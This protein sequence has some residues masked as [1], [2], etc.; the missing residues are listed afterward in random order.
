MLTMSTEPETA[1]LPGV[2][3]DTYLELRDQLYVG[4]SRSKR[5]FYGE[6]G[7]F[8]LTPSHRHEVLARL[9]SALVQEI[10]MSR[11]LR[12]GSALS[13]TLK[14]VDLHRAAEADDCIWIDNERYDQRAFDLDLSRMPAP[15]LVIEVDVTRSSDP[16]MPIYA[17]LGVREIWRVRATEDAGF[18]IGIHSLRDGACYMEVEESGVLPQLRR[19]WIQAE[20]ERG[21]ELGMT[22]WLHRLRAELPFG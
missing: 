2:A 9:V 13:T 5:V 21:Y 3:W 18:R 20:V 17:A 8:L 15:D 22:E 11:G 10:A 14:R 19:D 1:T 6:E 12:L 7:V 4:G 16:R